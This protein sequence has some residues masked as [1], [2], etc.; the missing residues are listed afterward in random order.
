MWSIGLLVNLAGSVLVTKKITAQSWTTS[1]RLRRHKIF[2]ILYKYNINIRVGIVVAAASIAL[3]LPVKPSVN[4]TKNDE[5]EIRPLI[6][7]LE[8]EAGINS[9][10][11]RDLYHN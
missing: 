8:E 9:D 7:D 6:A 1:V 2:K 11:R 5:D 10:V 4:K 3:Y